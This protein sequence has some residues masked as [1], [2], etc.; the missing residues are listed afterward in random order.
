MGNNLEKFNP[1]YS[2]CEKPQKQVFHNICDK[3]KKS[4]FMFCG[5]SQI[6]CVAWE[7]YEHED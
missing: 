7:G 4:T 2:K 3:I 6:K 5:D 1:D